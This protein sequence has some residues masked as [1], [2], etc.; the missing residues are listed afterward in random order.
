MRREPGD[1]HDSN[2]VET[3]VEQTD[4]L[5]NINDSRFQAQQSPLHHHVI[6]EQRW[7]QDSSILFNFVKGSVRTQQSKTAA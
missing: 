7:R 6:V 5:I 2:T 1:W 3:T 4:G